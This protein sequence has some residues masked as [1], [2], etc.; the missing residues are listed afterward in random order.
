LVKFE[1]GGF[2]RALLTAVDKARP[3]LEN[4]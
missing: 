2:K 3:K 1:A 4:P